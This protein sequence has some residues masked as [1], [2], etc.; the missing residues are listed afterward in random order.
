MT[1]DLKTLLL[2]AAIFSFTGCSEDSSSS[3]DG[4]IDGS[5]DTDTDT[6]TDSDSDTDPD[7]G[8]DAGIDDRVFGVTV[9]DPWVA[10]SPDC[11]LNT[12]LDGLVSDGGRRPTARVVFDEGIDQVFLNGGLDASAYVELVENISPH[13]IVMG[14]LLD[15]LYVEDY[16]VSQY[17]LRACE[18][19]ATLGHLV[20]IWE[21]GNEVNGE[22]L[23]DDVL[24]KLATA[25]EVFTAT[26]GAFESACPGFDVQLD[27]KPF[28][29]ALT[30]YYNGPYD[31]GIPT[32]NN[33]W[34]EAPH[35]M[36]FWVDEGFASEGAI[37]TEQIVPYLDLVLVS[38][39]EDDCDGIQPQWSPVFDHLGDIFPGAAL[40]F[41]EC[42]TEDETSKVGYVERYYQGMDLPNPEY[43][44]MHVDHPR[45]V[46]GYFWWYFN[47]DM[48]DPDVYGAL[49]AAL[50]GPFWSGSS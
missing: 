17:R 27:E 20:D 46:G 11:E 33:C 39:Y 21:I 7:A 16:D 45:F 15:S 22:W 49:E 48:G 10:E 6:D 19:R 2:C 32:G 47:E 14:E 44:N 4:G 43:A 24:E 3:T 35:A 31:G 13:A 12:R 18:Y 5:P 29:V 41:G 50:D 42:G 23:G 38:Y 8:A 9:T 34:S 26:T 1:M 36:N 40:G 25:T 37:G 30:F 28:Q